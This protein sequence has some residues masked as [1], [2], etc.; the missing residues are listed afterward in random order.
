MCEKKVANKDG[1]NGFVAIIH[2]I[3]VHKETI[4]VHVD[5]SIAGERDHTNIWYKRTM[6]APH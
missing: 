5:V 2:H 4:V 3:N 1:G 6:M